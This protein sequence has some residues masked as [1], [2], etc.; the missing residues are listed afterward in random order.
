MDSFE[1][2]S[3][4]SFQ[5]RAPYPLPTIPQS[6]FPNPSN[7]QLSILEYQDAEKHSMYAGQK[8]YNMYCVKMGRKKIIKFF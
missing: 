5:S 1:S 4:S 2:Q 3:K 7:N 8:G 6:P